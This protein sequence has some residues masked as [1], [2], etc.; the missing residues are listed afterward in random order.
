MLPEKQCPDTYDP[1]CAC[2]GLT[3]VNVCALREAGAVMNHHGPCDE[4]VEI[5][6][7]SC[8]ALSGCPAGSDL[9][10][11]AFPQLGTR[12]AKPDPCSYFECPKGSTCELTASFPGRVICTKPGSGSAGQGSPSDKTNGVP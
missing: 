8:D 12:C 6:E 10:C 5:T 7:Y 4:G 9:Q 1:V 11:Y 3:Y 2:D